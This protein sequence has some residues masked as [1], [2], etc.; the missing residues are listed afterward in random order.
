VNLKQNCLRM[1]TQQIYS[2]RSF[3]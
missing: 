2:C 1:T 3:I